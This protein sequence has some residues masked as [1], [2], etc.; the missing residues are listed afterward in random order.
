MAM[1]APSSGSVPAFSTANVTAR[2][3]SCCLPASE[4]TYFVVTSNDPD[5]P[6]LQVPVSLTVSSTPPEAVH[7]LVVFLDNG[8]MRLNW[9][10]TTL[11]TGYRVYRMSTVS[12][13]YTAGQLLTPTPITATTFLDTA[14]LDSTVRYFVY[15]VTAVR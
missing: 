4:E 6:T 14:A 10:P 1:A 2:L 13:Y 12:Q 3:Y 8:D 9:S 11:A 5:E 15:Q 7:D